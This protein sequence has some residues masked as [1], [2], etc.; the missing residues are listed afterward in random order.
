MA[1]SRL[2]L[3]EDASVT[4]TA[5]SVLTQGDRDA[6]GLRRTATRS[7]GLPG[8]RSRPGDSDTGVVSYLLIS[9]AS[10]LQPV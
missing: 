8:T 6:G 10:A 5:E 2:S 9:I 1:A 4:V 7:P 3:S